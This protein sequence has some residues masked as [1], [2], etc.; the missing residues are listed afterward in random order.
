MHKPVFNPF[1][2]YADQLE[3]EADKLLNK[4][5]Y[6]DNV[7]INK[8][9]LVLM[10]ENLVALNLWLEKKFK[11]YKYLSKWKRSTLYKNTDALVET[12]NKFCAEIRINEK[13]IEERYKEIQPSHHST[14]TRNKLK[15]L[16]CI[17][18]FLQP[19]KYYEYLEGASFGKLLNNPQKAKLI[20]DC[21]QIVTLYAFLYSLKYPIRDLKIKLLPNHVCLHFFGI[22]IEATNATFHKYK[23]FTHILNI[24]ELIST[25]LLDTADFRD[26]TLNIDSRTFIKAAELAVQISSIKDI[27][28]KNLNVAYHNLIVESSRQKDFDTATYYLKKISDPELEHSVYTNAAVYFTEKKV[29]KKAFYYADLARDQ[30]LK[31]YITTQEGWHYFQKNDLSKALQ[32]FKSI[33]NT[34]MEK[35]CYAKMYNNLQQKTAG[36]TTISQHRAHKNDYHKMLDL[37]RKMNDRPLEENLLK[38]LDSIK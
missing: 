26:K 19:G 25:N 23:D 37:A 10:Q 11:G 9:L 13:Y 27:T 12:F 2:K 3:K 30:K 7:Y 24:S 15:Y 20:G 29:Y 6:K 32:I 21:N 18:L 31:E 22:D 17:M 5:A 36:L 33:K 28:F 4:L 8:Q 38:L 34:E 14:E 16:Y 1:S 35:A